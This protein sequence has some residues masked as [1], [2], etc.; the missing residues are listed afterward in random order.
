MQCGGLILPIAALLRFDGLVADL[1]DGRP[2]QVALGFEVLPRLVPVMLRSCPFGIALVL[3]LFP[4]SG[5][6]LRPLD[7]RIGAVDMAV[8]YP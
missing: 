7:E 2:A 5:I 4:E 8:G 3:Y 6:E 1:F